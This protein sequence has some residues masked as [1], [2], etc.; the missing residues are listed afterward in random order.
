MSPI[1]SKLIITQETYEGLSKKTK[2][3]LEQHRISVLVVPHD[4]NGYYRHH[5]II[6]LLSY[7]DFLWQTLWEAEHNKAAKNELDTLKRS[8][9]NIKDI[10][11]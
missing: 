8:I 2:E 6:N 3:E 10:I 4:D 9:A 5:N 1:N 11:K 7:F